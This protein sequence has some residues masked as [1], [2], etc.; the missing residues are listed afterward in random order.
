MSEDER[1]RSAV[2]WQ[3]KAQALEEETRQVRKT[4]QTLQLREAGAARFL[5]NAVVGMHWLAPDCAILWS[6][7]TELELLGYRPQQYVGR[8]F[9]DF[10]E[11][12]AVANRSAPPAPRL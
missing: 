1:R 6:N 11:N 4:Q 12:P 8:N 9:A 2:V 5:E 3:Q 10:I 7:R